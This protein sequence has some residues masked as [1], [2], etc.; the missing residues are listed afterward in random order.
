MSAAPVQ[1]P[2]LPTSISSP[3]VLGRPMDPAPAP[4]VYINGWHGI[5]KETVAE[6]LTLL[7][8]KEKSLL[9]DVRSVGRSS[10]P[11]DHRHDHHHHHHRRRRHKHESERNPLLTPEHP[12]YF[13]F[14]A[15]PDNSD[16][17]SLGLASPTYSSSSTASR[18]ASISQISLE[19][20]TRLLASPPNHRRLAVLPAHAPD[21]P[22]GRALLGT[23][24]AAAAR[25]GRL[26]LCVELRCEMGV[27]RARVVRQSGEAMTAPTPVG[28]VMDSPV[29]IWR[30]GQGL[31]M[32]GRAGLTVDVTSLPAF[33]AALQIVEFV[34]ALEAAR[35]AELCGPGGSVATPPADG[36]GS[37]EEWMASGG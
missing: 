28:Q 36:S 30:A 2:R 9:I 26:F 6:C 20:L 10:S 8:G 23:L 3:N 21:T 29:G 35:D 34:R 17:T 22:A 16:P 5:G 7:L 32:A 13:S 24:E 33:E 15:D 4:L 25:A 37:R 27:Y 19:N 12:R 14:D 31:A 11:V 1:R 18:S